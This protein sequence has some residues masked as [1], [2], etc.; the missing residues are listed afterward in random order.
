MLH[1]RPFCVLK[2]PF[3][4]FVAE[5]N[6]ACNTEGFF[7]SSQTKMGGSYNPFAAEVIF[8]CYIEGL[9]VFSKK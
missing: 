3:T 4:P 7:L 2:E 6:F 5:V 1:R 9:F 8:P